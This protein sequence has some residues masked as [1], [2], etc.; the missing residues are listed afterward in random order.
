MIN[1]GEKSGRQLIRYCHY[2]VS[3]QGPQDFPLLFS[4]TQ[5]GYPIFQVPFCCLRRSFGQCGRNNRYVN[6]YKG[7]AA[8]IAF[9][10]NY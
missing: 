9:P 1:L 10:A 3:I 8:N 2:S 7:T 5:W 6:F 4:F